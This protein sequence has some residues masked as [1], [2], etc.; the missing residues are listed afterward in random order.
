MQ[1]IRDSGKVIG[2]D[3]IAIMAALNLTHELLNEQSRRENFSRD[4]IF[5]LRSVEERVNTALAMDNR[6]R[7]EAS[8]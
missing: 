2:A 8:S 1:Q 3:R 7:S 6:L 5:R 4:V